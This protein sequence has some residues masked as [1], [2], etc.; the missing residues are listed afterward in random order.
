MPKYFQSG[1]NSNKYNQRLLI[2][3]KWLIALKPGVW[4]LTLG[5]INHSSIQ[6]N[7]PGQKPTTL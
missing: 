6:S 4:A 1:K 2:L 3:T 7:F 5:A